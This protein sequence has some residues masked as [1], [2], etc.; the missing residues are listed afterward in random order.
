MKITS[1][2]AGELSSNL[3]GR[4]DLP[5]YYKGAAFLS[6]FDVIPTGGI[7]RRSGT[8]FIGCLE[9]AGR[10]IPFQVN[11]DLNF[12]LHLVPGKIQVYRV[13]KTV[14]AGAAKTKVMP[15]GLS[16]DYPYG[17][18]VAE[19]DGHALY[20]AGEIG[21]VQHAQ[22]HNTMILVHENHPPLEVAYREGT[23]HIGKVQM[24]FGVPI[25]ADKDIASGEKAEYEKEDEQYKDNGWL[26]TDGNYPAAVSFYN[27]RLV[28]AGTKND[29]QRLFFSAIKEPGKPYNFATKKI[30]L[31]IKPTY[32][33]VTGNLNGNS[34]IF[35]LDDVFQTLKFTRQPNEFFCDSSNI[36]EK[37]TQL[38]EIN[39]RTLRLSSK[40]NSTVIMTSDEKD[41][42]DSWIEGVRS[43][44]SNPFIF[45]MGPVKNGQ[46]TVNPNY[47]IKVYTAKIVI[48]Q[49][50]TS[51]TGQNKTHT[52]NISDAEALSIYNSYNSGIPWNNWF[53]TNSI[54]P[55]INTWIKEQWSNGS[56][57]SWENNTYYDDYQ[58][59][60]FEL[61]SRIGINMVKTFR[62][63]QYI[64][65]PEINYSRIKRDYYTENDS[66]LLS[67]Y[68]REKFIDCVPTPDCGFTFEIDSDASDAI[69]W[70][71]VN[72]GLIIGTEMSEWVIPP[73]AHATNHAAIRT[74]G[75]GSDRIQG[76]VIGDA[77]IF[78]TSGRR[79]IV[80]Y[81]PNENDHFRA[82]NLAL[83]APQMLTESPAKE[84]D[85]IASPYAKLLVTREDGSFAT[86]LY[87][88]MTGTFAWSRFG[89]NYG[90]MV[91]AAA[92]PGHDGYDD[93]YF[94]IE[95]KI[96]G[97]THRTMERLREAGTVYLDCWREWKWETEGQRQMLL[98]MYGQ[99]AW[100]YD[101]KANESYLPNRPA[102][103]PRPPDSDHDWVFVKKDNP[104]SAMPGIDYFYYYVMG[105][106]GKSEAVRHI[107]KGNCPPP[108]DKENPRYIGHWYPS[109]MRSMPV[110]SKDKT[111][112]PVSMTTLHVRLHNSYVPRIWGVDSKD[113]G[114]VTGV[115]K[116][117]NPMRGPSPTLQFEIEHRMPTPCR[118]LA[119]DAE[120]T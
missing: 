33:A 1:F 69:R 35:I 100:I 46:T 71:A 85:F 23:L 31:N 110:V 29:P 68:Y 75:H 62:G 64:G 90:D 119:V 39:N 70:L 60:I 34:N 98:D 28:F 59:F 14:E 36:F 93:I 7:K 67:F 6:N 4:S 109:R 37:G 61:N 57:N 47:R 42:L 8:E 55:I 5:Q 15:E 113:T 63:K 3:F 96:A 43:L 78:F 20:E 18:P 114:M 26:T 115:V 74:S 92:L 91:S 54:M 94:I 87:E 105:A 2:S 48:E 27:G 58:K 104:N 95:R 97:E 80:E 120:A 11:R 66:L 51:G 52:I 19:V 101:Q 50:D 116:I 103:P 21:E 12:L 99:D 84:F 79:G 73:D 41:E 108:S 77:T 40:S 38:I 81:Y 118:I 44:E 56:L 102:P 117:A 106:D 107:P 83:L 89:T 49:Y 9:E 30:F 72:R 88:R 86:L 25:D 17:K 45:N 53:V 16:S 65:I 82:N 13:E 32:I 22:K 76:T 111:M 10:L 112:Q 24:D